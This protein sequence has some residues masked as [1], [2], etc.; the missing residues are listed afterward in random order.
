MKNKFKFALNQKV[1]IIGTT[2]IC[3]INGRGKC[4]FVSGGKAN[5]Y[6]LA[7]CH[8]GV[9]FE[10]E[11]ESIFERKQFVKVNES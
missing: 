5:A 3:V 9:R 11:L 2:G 1:F 10:H 8:A 6:F 4:K 7:G